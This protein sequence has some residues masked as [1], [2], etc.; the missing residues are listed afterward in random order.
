MM[1]HE[2]DHEHAEIT[3]R[4]R[5][6]LRMGELTPKQAQAEYDA[7]IPAELS[8][9]KIDAL[10]DGAFEQ[11]SPPSERPFEV[12]EWTPDADTSDVE[13]DVYQLNR[14]EGEP[15]TEVDDLIEK[16]RR[17]AFD[18]ETSGEDPRDDPEDETR[19]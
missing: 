2:A 14:N 7:A 3:R 10:V 18:E 17:E 16:H 19:D 5:R 13:S 9:A 1:A 6:A 8:D 12:R 11:A 4:L 15:D